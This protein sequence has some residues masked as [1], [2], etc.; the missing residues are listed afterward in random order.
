MDGQSAFSILL[1]THDTTRTMIVSLILILL[2]CLIFS[3]CFYYAT[4]LPQKFPRNIP[5][6]SIY[7]QIYDT[8]RGLSRI[9]FYNARIRLHMEKR[10]A[11][12]LW[13]DGQWT[14]LIA[15]PE[16]LC[17]MFRDKG[18]S[19]KRNG[20]Y[21]R[22]PGGI[23]AR[24][25]GENIVDSDGDLHDQFCEIIK[26]G[27]LMR[28][29]LTSIKQRT[30]QLVSR[31]LQDQATIAPGAGV[32]IS[33]PVFQWSVYVY[34]EQFLDLEFAPLD[35][36][37]NNVQAIL[38]AQNRSTLARLK[39]MFPIIDKVPWTWNSTRRTR[40]LFENL[41]AML[42]EHT[43]RRLDQPPS[44]GSEN[45]VIYRMSQALAE[46]TMSDFHYRCNMNQLFVAG[47]EN[48][49]SALQSILFE[50]AKNEE[51]QERLHCELMRDLPLDYSD[52]D[53]SKLP[54]L[55]AVIYE[56]LRLYPP[57]AFMTNRRTKVPYLLGEDLMLP[58][59]ILIGRNVYGTHTN[60]DVWCNPT[61][62]NPDRWGKD[63]AT[64]H[65]TFRLEQAQ[66]RYVPFGLHSRRCLGSRF[67]VT[68]LKISICEIVRTLRWTLPTGHR[69]SFGNVCIP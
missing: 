69:F 22:V 55:T 64:I 68:E 45:K 30:A 47:A 33:D 37:E 31:L 67:A 39:S 53:M 62:F 4:S 13:H 58:A 48:V 41:E 21:H 34:G 42:I 26:P 49:E 43:R 54:L 1:L 59:G 27:I 5:I 52:D 38:S 8:F 3:F 11:V 17:Q 66:G 19:L 24:L 57:L 61:V 6:I 14:V 46:G 28:H 63:Y 23:A 32:P 9:D 40:R 7:T 18:E 10:G 51:I 65:K 50:L 56:T 44:P 60:P 36:S 12:G 16:Y 15:K 25:F 29:N 35:F 2:P 20:F